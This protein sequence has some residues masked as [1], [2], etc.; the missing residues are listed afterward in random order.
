MRDG[1]GTTPTS[2]SGVSPVCVR[3]EATVR[4]LIGLLHSN[5]FRHFLVTEPEGKLLGVVSD[6]D[7]LRLL[8]LDADS[9]ESRSRLDTTTARD[10]M[11]PDV[12]E[13]FPGTPLIQVV[14]TLLR[15]GIS[16]VPVVEEGI[17]IGIL[18]ST[19]LFLLLELMLIG[20]AVVSQ[21]YAQM[22]QRLGTLGAMARC[23]TRESLPKPELASA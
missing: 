12:L 8:G 2:A 23:T 22:A 11:S 13:V 18:T 15:Y 20:P 6:R 16:C 21:E 19:D 9:A 17:P 5:R 14:R 4:E 1:F 3:P 10:L 7:I